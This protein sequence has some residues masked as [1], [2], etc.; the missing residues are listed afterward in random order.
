M[1][2]PGRFASTEVAKQISR[3]FQDQSDTFQV[4]IRYEK[5][6]DAFLRKAEQAQRLTANSKL[7][8]R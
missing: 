5:E 4:K 3:A 6:V 2:A 7:T 8:F 1:R